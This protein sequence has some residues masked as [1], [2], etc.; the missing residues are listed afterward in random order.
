MSPARPK[1]K[2][3]A[4]PAARL[5][6]RQV[7]AW[8]L[9]RHHLSGRAPSGSMLEV[10]AD[11]CGVHAQLS[12]SAELTLWARV[13]GLIPPAVQAALWEERSLVKT[14]AMR[15]TLHLLDAAEFPLW[16]A[17]LSTYGHYR[18]AS[19]L[20]YFEVT[21]EDLERL[22]DAV[23]DALDGRTLTREEL[24]GEVGRLTGSAAL[25]DKLRESWGALLKPA[26]YLGRLCYAPSTGQQVRFT[27]PDQW[28]G[29]WAKVDPEEALLAVTR[30]FLA[31]YGP[32]SREDC[33]RWWGTTP[34]HAAR[35]IDGLGDD[36]TPVEADGAPAWMLTDHVAEAAEASASG[37][38]R[39]LPAFDQY[40]VGAPRQAP[41]VLAPDFKSRVY[42]PQGWLSPVLLVDGR[43]E[44]VWRHERK[45]G[46][47]VVAIEPFE[48][49]SARVR[50]GAEA[51]AERLAAFAGGS[52]EVS[53][54][55]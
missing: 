24:A 7:R 51:E 5:S 46:R 34:A 42:R 38:V 23:T 6:G 30:R 50:R 8:R 53:W 10:V 52:L 35:L 22:L 37:S 9:G 25:G 40:V 12:S 39:L 13:E 47:L 4:A 18:K 49:A 32:G 3:T 19:W 27:R 48:K 54:A 21:E 1:A 29:G 41:D 20:R 44:G 33:A 31:S 2:T 36:V 26:A 55:A 45:G 17:A 14:W 15:G 43:M 16:Q 11:L 28:L